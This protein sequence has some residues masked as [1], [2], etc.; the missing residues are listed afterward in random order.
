MCETSSG[1]ILVNIQN[2]RRNLLFGDRLVFVL[3]VF[4]QLVSV[5]AQKCAGVGETLT[6][7]INGIKLPHGG[8]Q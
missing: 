4:L 7:R 8:Q 5:Q 6:R 2:G 3:L 1:G